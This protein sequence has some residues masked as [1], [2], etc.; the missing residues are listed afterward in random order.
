MKRIINKIGKFSF[1]G[2]LIFSLCSI[3]ISASSN[4][5]CL[6][7]GFTIDSEVYDIDPIFLNTPVIYYS[8]YNSIIIGAG[9]F[10]F[11]PARAKNIV[12]NKYQH[13]EYNIKVYLIT[14]D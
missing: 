10:D 13:I 8:Y 3:N 1:V 5:T 9:V 2:L 11:I 4:E 7:Y 12:N 6:R 14:E